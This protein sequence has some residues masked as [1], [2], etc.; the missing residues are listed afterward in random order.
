[1]IGGFIISGNDAKTVL[2]RGIG[3]S[4][5]NAGLNNVLDDPVLELHGSNGALI[6]QNDNWRDTQEAQIQ[7]SGLQPSVDR[8]AAIFATLQPGGYTGI[9]TGKNQTTGV[10][11]VEFY[12]LNQAANAQLRNLSTRGLVQNADN[13]MIGGFILGGNTGTTRVAIRGIGPSLTQSG[14]SGVLANPTLELHDGNGATLI[15][16]DNWGDDQGSAAALSANNLAP[17]NSLESGI[18]TT[19]TPGPYTVILAGKNGGTGIGLV[20]VYNLQ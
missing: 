1:M 17:P 8:E 12:D 4:L 10:G 20:E 13:V 6:L 7:N 9:L 18:F 19:L 5:A 11:L 16:N 14:L 3:P 15:S 2:L